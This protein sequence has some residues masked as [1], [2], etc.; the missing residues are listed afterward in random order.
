MAVNCDTWEGEGM[1]S[2]T[3]WRG[4]TLGERAQDRREQFIAAGFRLIGADGTGR[5]PCAPCAAR[6]N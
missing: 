3:V 1:E 4:S 6:P 5:P 2:P